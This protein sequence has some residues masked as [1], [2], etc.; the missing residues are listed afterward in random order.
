VSDE[1]RAAYARD[2]AVCVRGAISPA[3]V[4]RLRACADENLRAPGPLC[5]EHVPAGEPGRFHDDQ[6]L[7]RRH[8]TARDFVHHS[9]AAALAQALAAPGRAMS[10]FYDQLFVKEPGTKTATP[11]H[12]DH[13]YWHL[14]GGAVVSL[15]APLDSVPGATAVRYVAGSHAWGLK[16]Q[17]ASFSGDAERYAASAALPP[18]PDIDALEARGEVRVLRWDVEP[19]DVIVFDSYTVHGAPGN[20][21]ASARRRAYATRW[22]SED[23]RFDARAG[24][25]HYT[26][27]HKAGLDCGLQH[28]DPLAAPMHPR[29]AIA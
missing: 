22:A 26:W 3:W 11:W 2:G 25:M 18:L 29:I 4:E 15:W 20:S 10:I 9:P 8:A 28:G 16:H 12:T 19:G 17:I 1:L 27:V 23:A 7:W 24:T 5:D 13:S 14:A 21:S 6:F